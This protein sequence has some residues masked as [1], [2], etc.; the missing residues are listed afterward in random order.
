MQAVRPSKGEDVMATEVR[1]ADL[2]EGSIVAH[3]R[4]VYLR[5]VLDEPTLPWSVTEFNG[6]YVN[7][8]SDGEV[9]CALELGATVLRHG[10]GEEG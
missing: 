3:G 8:A 2:P 7:Y 4:K 9:D 10:Y 5:Y 1:A 6:M